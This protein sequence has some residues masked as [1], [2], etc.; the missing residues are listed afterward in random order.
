MKQF[1][2]GTQY[3]VEGKVRKVTK[4]NTKSVYFGRVRYD[5]VTDENGDQHIV[6]NN[7]T[8]I[9][10]GSNTQEVATEIKEEEV[11]MAEEIKTTATETEEI[12]NDSQKAI[13][14][15]NAVEAREEAAETAPKNT[16]YV[17]MKANKDDTTL[18]WDVV[19]KAKGEN[20]SDII[21]PLHE[22]DNPKFVALVSLSKIRKF[23]DDPA[24]KGMVQTVR[25]VT[26]KFAKVSGVENPAP[27]LALDAFEQILEDI[28][29]GVRKGAWN[30]I[31]ALAATE[32]DAE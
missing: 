22:E 1:E 12:V 29:A 16:E 19:S 11:T 24:I 3:A 10:A 30:A 9:Y 15:I 5:I 31:P 6:Q 13:D 20:I 2:V 28:A 25:D 18:W 17:V 32:E 21:N 27:A 7:G 4:V 26:K 14:V 8:A 23:V